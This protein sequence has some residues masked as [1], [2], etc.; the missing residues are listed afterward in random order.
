M[1]KRP[2]SSRELSI[3]DRRAD[4]THPAV[5]AGALI[6]LIRAYRLL[7]APAF[8]SACRFA[9]SCSRYAAEAL[10]RHGAARGAV[11]AVRR[12]VRCHPWH[13]G[14]NDPVPAR[15]T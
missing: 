5:I 12:V 9:P 14:G 6:L 15:R 11:L 4:V 8:P 10:E 7:L 1:P 3:S 2:P 13:A